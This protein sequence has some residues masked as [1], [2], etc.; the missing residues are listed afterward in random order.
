MTTA[1]LPEPLTAAR[2]LVTPALRESVA[3]LVPSMRTIAEYHLGWRDA[4]GQE[5]DSGGG[6]TGKALRPALVLLSAQAAGAEAKRA[7]PA[8]VGVELVHNFS[9]LHDD[10]MDG[11]EHRRHRPTAWRVFGMPA[12]ILAG[13]ALLT[14]AIE[15]ARTECEPAFAGDAVGCLDEAVQRLIAGQSSDMGFE[16]RTD[17]RLEECLSMAADKTGALMRCACS[18]G[19]I[20]VG[21][22]KDVTGALGDFGEH[23]GLAFQLVDDLL[24]IRGAPEVTGKPALSDLR[25]KKKSVPVVVALNSGTAEGTELAEAY[26][27]TEPVAE[28]ELRGLAD[29]VQRAGGLDV[30]E[31]EARRHVDAAHG[32]LERVGA[33]REIEDALWAT[34]RFVTRRDQ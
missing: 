19:A 34:A 17:V 18:I 4:Q 21:A 33:P 32:C 24:G 6:K 2:D 20:A 15:I 11:D 3:G 1:T 31:R 27:R 5:R 26:L 30:T 25:S 12:A 14:L 16:S 10:V 22:E 8:A 9:L 13:D 29:L 23:I 7:L 28:D